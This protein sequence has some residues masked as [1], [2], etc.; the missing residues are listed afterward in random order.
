MDTVAISQ[1]HLQAAIAKTSGSALKTCV[2]DLGHV[3]AT[4]SWPY[5]LGAREPQGSCLCHVAVHLIG[6]FRS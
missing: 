1:P 5:L 6:G 4:S 2:L 3:T